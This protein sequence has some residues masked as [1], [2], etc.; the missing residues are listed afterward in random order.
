MCLARSYRAFSRKTVVGSAPRRRLPTEGGTTMKSRIFASLALCLSGAAMGQQPPLLNEEYA[1]LGNFA[2]LA[3]GN[4]RTQMQTFPVD[5]TGLLTRVDVQA[6]RQPQTVADLVLSVW[7]IDADGLPDQELFTASVPASGVPLT[8]TRPWVSFDITAARFI[9]HSGM[10]L[11]I[12]LDSAAENTLPFLE[13]WAWEI[14]GFYMRGMSYTIV[15]DVVEGHAEDFHFRTYVEPALRGNMDIKPRNER[16]Q[17]NPR[18]GGLVAIAVFTEP[19]F[20]AT[21]LDTASVRFGADAN[22]AVPVGSGAVDVNGDGLDDLVLRFR[23]RETGIQCGDTVAWLS[24][25][26]RAGELFIAGDEIVT[27]GCG[28]STK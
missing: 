2:A 4:D 21:S 17:L 18:S 27:V 19:G 20:D 7:S 25:R 28:G 10:R 26:T 8:G 16:N 22:E 14:G 11:G 24:G 13:R 23:L 3:V 6:G 1:P 5:F 15:S 12:A 9:V